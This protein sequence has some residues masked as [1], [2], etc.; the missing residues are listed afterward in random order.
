[1]HTSA[2]KIFLYEFPVLFSCSTSTIN[3][4]CFDAGFKR[5]LGIILPTKKSEQ[6]LIQPITKGCCFHRSINEN[7]GQNW[8]SERLRQ[9]IRGCVVNL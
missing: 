7:L 2:F 5:A 1:M 9:M 4:H 3:C 6:F 8:P